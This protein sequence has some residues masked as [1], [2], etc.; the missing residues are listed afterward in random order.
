MRRFFRNVVFAIV[1]T[2]YISFFD[3]DLA[4][5]LPF[6]YAS[7]MDCS[8]LSYFIV[9]LLFFFVIPRCFSAG[10]YSFQEYPVFFFNIWN[11]ANIIFQN[12]KIN[13]LSRISFLIGMIGY[14]P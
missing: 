2:S 13:F 4:L 5:I 8:S 12:N 11:H 6:S 3:G 1:L 14:L 7:K 9:F 10:D